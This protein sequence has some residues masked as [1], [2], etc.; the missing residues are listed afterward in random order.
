MIRLMLFFLLVLM[1]LLAH[2]L[3]HDLSITE[4]DRSLFKIE[5]FGFFAGG[6]MNIKVSDFHVSKRTLDKSPMRIGK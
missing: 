6:T 3:V 5:T 2:G 1:L 4:D